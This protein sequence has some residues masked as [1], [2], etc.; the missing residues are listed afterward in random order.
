MAIS[1]RFRALTARVPQLV[2][3]QLL[4]EVSAFQRD[5]AR[6]VVAEIRTYP[7]PPAMSTYVRTFQLYN[8]WS[9]QGPTFSSGGLVTKIVNNTPYARF[10]QGNDQ[11][12]FHEQTGWKR[13][14]DFLDRSHYR[15][16]L[17]EVIN[18]HIRR[19]R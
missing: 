15:S 7:P 9:V 18:D 4:G 8:G 6:N 3:L 2:P 14:Q 17:Q 10:V 5:W 1:V 13:I 19:H 11:T 12:W 16:E